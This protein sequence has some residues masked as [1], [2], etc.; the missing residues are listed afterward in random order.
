MKTY[1]HGGR[2]TN[3]SRVSKRVTS[4]LISAAAAAITLFS[5]AVSAADRNTQEQEEGRLQRAGNG[6]G[7]AA[8]GPGPGCN[9]IPPLASIGTKVDISQFPPP[10]SLTNPDLAGPVQLWIRER[11]GWRKLRNVDFSSDGGERRDDVA[12]GAR[13]IGSWSG[14]VPGSLQSAFLLLLCVSV[15]CGYRDRKE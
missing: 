12:S 1:Q 7:P 13:S 4:V 14:T 3:M 11:V 2:R 6:P 8:N 10:D 15:C 5:V 9:I